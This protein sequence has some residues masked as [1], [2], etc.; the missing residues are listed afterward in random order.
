M[1]SRLRC[2][3][4]SLPTFYSL[5]IEPSH[6]RRRTTMRTADG[7]GRNVRNMIALFAL[8]AVVAMVMITASTSAASGLLSSGKPLG[9]GTPSPT[10]TPTSCG[11]SWN[12]VSIPSPGSLY[13][14]LSG[15]TA[16]APND[17]W[18]VGYQTSTP[19]VPQSL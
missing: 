5:Q 2:H 3:E 15:I 11:L 17:I 1:S 8:L 9:G 16:L 7:A 10:S 18:A 19:G 6:V 13:N 12:N 14:E 4:H